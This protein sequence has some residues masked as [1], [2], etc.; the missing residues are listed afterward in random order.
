VTNLL[1]T[2]Q[3]AVELGLSKS[4]LEHWRTVRKGPP[5]FRVG[6]RCIRYRRADLDAWLS[7]QLIE[8]N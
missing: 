1:N 5:F 6:P 4:T 7:E 3:A 2:V 8:A